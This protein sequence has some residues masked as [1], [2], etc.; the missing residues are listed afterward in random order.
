MRCEPLLT[1][2][3]FGRLVVPPDRLTEGDLG[4]LARRIGLSEGL[5]CLLQIAI[6]ALGGP[7]SLRDASQELLSGRSRS[8]GRIGPFTWNATELSQRAVPPLTVRGHRNAG[9][10]IGYVSEISH[11]PDIP[12]QAL[13]GPTS[14]LGYLDQ[15]EHGSSAVAWRCTGWRTLLVP[16]ADQCPARTLELG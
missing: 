15:I 16:A 9:E 5:T 2:R 14:G 1:I 11:Q 3:S 8:E 7:L 12:E 4:G 13:H 10:G 6:G